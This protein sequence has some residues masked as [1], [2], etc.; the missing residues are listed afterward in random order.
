MPKTRAN[1]RQL[2]RRRIRPVSV[3]VGSIELITAGLDRYDWTDPYY[4]ALD[5]PWRWFF[6]AVLAYEFLANAMFASL[7]LLRPGAIANLPPGSWSQAFFFSVETF[8]TVGYGVMAPVSTYGHVL[9]TM[10]IFCGLTSTAVITGLLFVRLSRPRSRLVFARNLVVGP[11]D[12][13]TTLSV[14]FVN[15]RTS[16]IY[17]ADVRFMLGMRETT[18][19]GHVFWRTYELPLLQ[20]PTRLVSLFF[21]ASHEIDVHSPLLGMTAPD[22]EAAGAQFLISVSGTDATLAAPIHAMQGYRPADVLFGYSF[23]DILSLDAN[24]RPHIDLRRVHE[25]APAGPVAAKSD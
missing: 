14:R 5:L 15:Q 21:I 6:A 4:T 3:R 11:I 8:A 23:C 22:L 10:E 25:V 18:T 20:E 12:G 13:K 9:A 1:S 19:E 2:W 17:D 24:N 7:Y 16:L